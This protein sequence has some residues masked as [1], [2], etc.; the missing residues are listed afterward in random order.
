MHYGKQIRR[1]AQQE[2]LSIYFL[3][4]YCPELAPVE[5][6]FS[7]IKRR[8]ITANKEKKFSFQKDEGKLAIFKALWEIHPT[9]IWKIWLEVIKVVKEL[10]IEWAK[11]P[12]LQISE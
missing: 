1:L 6:T 9:T 10:I 7:L 5:T 4:T 2:N 3:P 8:I 11:Q 12:N